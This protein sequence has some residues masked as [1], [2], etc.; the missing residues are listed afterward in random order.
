[1]QAEKAL[2]I[3][4]RSDQFMDRFDYREV[5]QTEYN[6]GDTPS[7]VILTT[8]NYLVFNGAGPATL[9]NPEFK[10]AAMAMYRYAEDIH[11]LAAHSQALSWY[12]D[13]VPYPLSVYIAP[14]DQY[15]LLIKQPNFTEPELLT[16]AQ[17]ADHDATG[18]AK[19]VAYRR[20]AEGTEVQLLTQGPVTAD[21]P[22][23]D[24]LAT[25]MAA[26]DMRRTVE[27]HREVYLDN[28][29]TTSAEQVR[30]LV[31]IPVNATD[32]GDTD[33]PIARN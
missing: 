3:L 29:L 7:L 8:R 25:F 16:Q 24:T 13:Y 15:T 27:G 12:R 28:I 20:L 14:N 31:R 30:T 6:L 19:Q 32:Q 4:K 33:Y 10:D 5:E 22:V 2:S 11:Q 18:A 9:T 1:M 17:Q 26:H 21:N 23:W